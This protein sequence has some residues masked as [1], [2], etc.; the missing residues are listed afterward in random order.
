MNGGVVLSNS[1]IRMNQEGVVGLLVFVGDVTLSGL[2]DVEV[3]WIMT[4]YRGWWWGL[5]EDNVSDKEVVFSSDDI[6]QRDREKGMRTKVA[7]VIVNRKVARSGS[8]VWSF[9]SLQ[10]R[11]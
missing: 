9:L 7:M 10:D 5:S 3:R 2:G 6:L 11:D 4:M 1:S 8:Y